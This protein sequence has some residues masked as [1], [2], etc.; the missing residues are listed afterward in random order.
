MRKLSRWWILVL[1][2]TPLRAQQPPGPGYASD[3]TCQICHPDIWGAFN[4]NAHFKIIAS[5]KPVER[6]FGCEGCHGPGLSHAEGKGDT[7]KINR[8]AG[9][10]PQQVLDAC[11]H[12]HSKDFSRSN[13]RRSVHT[14][15]DVVCTSCHLIHRSLAPKYLLAK[16]QR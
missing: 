8:I 6:T 5:P 4:K 9:R 15:N 11:L 16:L 13:I 3:A 14:S 1:F 7:T 12:C 2:L 10:P